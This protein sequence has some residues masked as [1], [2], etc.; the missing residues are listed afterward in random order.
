MPVYINEDNHHIC[1]IYQGK[2]AISPFPINRTD[3]RYYV[4]QNYSG[5]LLLM[6]DH[7]SICKIQV[8][9]F[10]L[11]KKSNPTHFGKV[12]DPLFIFVSEKDT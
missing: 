1:F 11:V 3:F 4:K 9:N 6:H 8:F 12:I 5:L 7:L 2:L 10:Y